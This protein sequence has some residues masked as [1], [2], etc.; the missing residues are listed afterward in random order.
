[1]RRSVLF[2]IL[3]LIFGVIGCATEKKEKVS[4]SYEQP[5]ATEKKQATQNSDA[6]KPSETID[7]STKGIGPVTAV[8]LAPKIDSEMA[9]RGK[10]TFRRTCTACHEVDRRLVGPPMTGITKKRTPEWIMNLIINP[11]EMALKDPLA[12]ALLE[13]YKQAI[14]PN[15]GI[16]EA[17]AR[18]ILEYFRQIDAE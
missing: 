5:D 2:P 18:E 10:A 6:P 13:E 1:M 9:E 15:Q 8:T 3:L 4:F 16:T 14:M 12:K 11:Q 17:Q 7:L